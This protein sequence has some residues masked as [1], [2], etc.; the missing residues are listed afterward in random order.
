VK[1]A[2]AM[3]ALLSLVSCDSLDKSASGDPVGRFQ[4]VRASDGQQGVYVLD[5]ENGNV[6]LCIGDPKTPPTIDCGIPHKV[7][8]TGANAP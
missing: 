1:A 4:M 3:V 8:E 5:T 6:W 2:L 7:V